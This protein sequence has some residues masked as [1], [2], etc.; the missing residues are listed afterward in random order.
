[1]SSRTDLLERLVDRAALSLW[2]ITSPSVAKVEARRAMN[3][4]LP[5][6]REAVCEE[7]AAALEADPY[8][9]HGAFARRAAEIARELGTEI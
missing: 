1:M 7:V 3:A 2:S 9:G 4:V 6:Y 8:M 5:I